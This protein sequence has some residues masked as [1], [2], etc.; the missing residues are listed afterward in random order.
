MARGVEEGT[1]GEKGL[2]DGRVECT[3]LR[4]EEPKRG[5]VTLKSEGS[6]GEAGKEGR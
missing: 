4:R 2:M 3:R 1:D 5:V 6:G